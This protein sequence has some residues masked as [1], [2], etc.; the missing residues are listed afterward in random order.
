M[1]QPILS[2]SEWPSNAYMVKKHDKNFNLEILILQPEAQKAYG[3]D[4]DTTTKTIGNTTNTATTTTTTTNS[5]TITEKETCRGKAA[6]CVNEILSGASEAEAAS[7]A[8]SS[9]EGVS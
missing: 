3:F 1:Y 7:D 2:V 5:T 6:E 9:R 8:G 4:A